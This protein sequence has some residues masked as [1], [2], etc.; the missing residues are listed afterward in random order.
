MTPDITRRHALATGA[1]SVA[2]ALAGCLGAGALA[3]DEPPE[4]AGEP[5]TPAERVEVTATSD[6]Y[7]KFEPQIVHV[8]EGGTVEWVVEIGRH[9]VTGYHRDEHPPHHAPEDAAPWGSERMST[10]G[11]SFERTFDEPGVYDYVDTQQVCVAH[12]IAGNVGR[13]IV[14]WPDPDEEPA[15]EP[16]DE[17]LPRRVYNA[18]ELFNE[19]TR[20]VLEDGP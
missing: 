1:T 11:A 15:V 5:G 17:D 9:D 8:R 20:P 3:E 6:P 12:E 4:D 13:V 18:F 16:P 7:P 10:A 14:G 2:A 19:E